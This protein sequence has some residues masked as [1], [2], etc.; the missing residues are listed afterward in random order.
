MVQRACEKQMA[1]V[2]RVGNRLLAQAMTQHQE[3]MHLGREDQSH[4]ME[5][6][7]A[8]RQEERTLRE[9]FT[10]LYTQTL[11]VLRAVAVTL[12]A[13][14]AAAGTSTDAPPS[15]QGSAPLEACVE[16]PPREDAHPQGRAR[17]GRWR[18]ASVGSPSRQCGC[19]ATRSTQGTAKASK[20]SYGTAHPR[21]H[22]PQPC[23]HKTQTSHTLVKTIKALLGVP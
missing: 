9:T 16:R 4:F 20:G 13:P 21:A 7:D 14:V 18:P 23:S 10:T 5:A 22:T 19:S 3:V 2:H 6:M 15:M 12:T 1:A 8:I 11:N 17:R